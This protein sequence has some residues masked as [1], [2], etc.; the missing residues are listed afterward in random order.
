VR[1]TTSYEGEFP[2]DIR[3]RYDFLEVRN[4]ASVI[5]AANP[6][7]FDD[8]VDVLRH[9]TLLRS[10]VTEPG[11]NRSELVGRLDRAFKQRGWREGSHRLKI[12]STVTKMPWREAGERRPA[13]TEDTTISDGY[14][15]DS[16]RGRVALDVE[17]NA[18]DG[19]LDRDLGAY[20]A[21]Y[22]EAII[23]GAIM[24]TR[25]SDD[26]RG[27]GAQMGVATWLGTTTTTNIEK[28]RDRL[29]RGSAG[30]CPVL[31]IAITARCLA[32]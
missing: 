7:E 4:A 17:W 13:E 19:N 32:A 11:R 14:K 28:L 6:G 1:L 3:A 9:F 23:D 18:K 27:L 30:G 24:L 29:A 10:D 26:L 25:S 22:D 5:R 8:V 20:R 16:L 12:V 31:A 2:A 15:V 21:F